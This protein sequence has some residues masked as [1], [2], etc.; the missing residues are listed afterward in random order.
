MKSIELIRRENLHKLVTDFG[1]QSKLVAALGKSQA[2]VSQW[3]T[4]SKMPSGKPRSISSDS[5]R[6]IEKIL[7]LAANWMDTPTN[8]PH[9]SSAAHPP[10]SAGWPL[11]LVSQDQ[12]ALLTHAEKCRVQ[13]HMADEIEKIIAARADQPTKKAA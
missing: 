8:A 12:Y 11:D 3:L 5:A 2:Q 9:S 13:V 1:N 6:E 7:G 10:Q 4:A